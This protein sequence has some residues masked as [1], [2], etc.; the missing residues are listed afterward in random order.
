VGAKICKE[1]S[2]VGCCEAWCDTLSS[3]CGV[4]ARYFVRLAYDMLCRN[5]TIFH[6]LDLRI[7]ENAWDII[8][9]RPW[10]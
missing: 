6:I 5:A 4:V 9:I 2:K 8:S 10:I 7:L 3:K 1:K